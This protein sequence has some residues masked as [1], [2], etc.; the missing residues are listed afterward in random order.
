MG[1][2]IN[3]RT[4]Q[5]QNAPQSVSPRLLPGSCPHASA[6]LSSC[7]LA[8]LLPECGLPSC[9]SMQGSCVGMEVGGCPFHVC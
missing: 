5:C 4:V 9:E 6:L 3:G 2:L 8:P 7:T 1:S